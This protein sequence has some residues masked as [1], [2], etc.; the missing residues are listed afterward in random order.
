MNK[1]YNV[2]VAILFMQTVSGSISANEKVT[3]QNLMNLSH[4]PIKSNITVQTNE[5]GE[6]WLPVEIN[7][8]SGKMLVDTGSSGS[9]FRQ[10]KLS[11]LED[12]TVLQQ[13]TG[14]GAGT[15]ESKVEST[16]IQLEN[17]SVAGK[18]L[19]IKQISSH[20]FGHGGDEYLGIIGLDVI[21][22]L[23]AG[24]LIS[25]QDV[26]LL[27]STTA[28]QRRFSVPLYKSDFGLLYFKTEIN[29]KEV[30]LIV[31]S[32]SQYTVIDASATEGLEIK[33]Q[34]LEGQYATDVQGNTIPISITPEISLK[35]GGNTVFTSPL[36]S[37]SL[38]SVLD[39]DKFEFN[40]VGVIGMANLQQA[41]TLIDFSTNTLHFLE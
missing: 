26:Q 20:V 30:G 41:K 21:K 4:E 3:G 19:E 10:D 17:F 16:L 35:V 25:Q 37:T 28:Y 15:T 8:L 27:G 22:E 5:F 12:F 7:N 34:V 23:S 38:S 1:W 40:V 9:V 13:R 32:G 29:E 36:L 39:N 31:D 6:L 33:T 18:S 11:V 14:Y 24:L 2:C